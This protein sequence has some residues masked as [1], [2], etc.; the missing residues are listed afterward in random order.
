MKN[1]KRLTLLLVAAAM[2]VSIGGCSKK[3]GKEEQKKFDNFLN[4][5]FKSTMKESY[6]NT[7]IFL[8][9]P[10]KYGINKDK[11]PLQ[12]DTLIS[13][14]KIKEIRTET[15][16]SAEKF[17]EFDRDLLTD[18]QKDN[19][20]IYKYMLDINV[21]SNYEKYDYISPVFKSMSGMHTQLPILFAD[22]TIRNED[23]IKDII[24]V[25]KSTRTYIN[26]LLDYTKKQEEKGTLMVDIDSVV[27]YCEDIIK[28]KE[29]SSVLTGLNGSIDEL[30]L[31]ANKT[32]AYK[33]QVKDAFNSSF[34]P[35]Y[36]DIVKVMKKLDP[37]K[38]NTLGLS[39]LKD[40]KSYYE[41]LFHE[42]SGSDK[43]ILEVQKDLESLLKTSL[44][45]VQETMSN[46]KDALKLL[47][48]YSK[49]KYTDFNQ[50]MKDL[51]NSISKDF[52][53]VGKIDYQIEP[54][55][56][57]LASSGIA[58]YFNLP[59]IDG[60][61]PKQIRVNT[62]KNT[63]DIS[64]LE[65]FM[66][67]AHEGLPGHM[68]QTAYAYKNLSSPWRNAIAHLT[69]Y[70]EG[71]A[72]YVE[73]YSL[74]YLPDVPKDVATIVQNS[75]VFQN[76]IIALVDIGIH[77]EGW[78][79]EQTK[80][81]LNGYGLGAIDV[82]SLYKQIQANPASFLPYY[83]GY[84]EIAELKTQAQNKLKDKFNDL[85]FHSAILKSG[86]APFSIVERNVNDY[87]EATK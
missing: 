73:L 27:N 46:N 28:N 57:E 23:D 76:C 69:S 7:H 25:M 34:I 62:N 22:I 71:Y 1:L 39:N 2:T 13:D 85:D 14:D 29:N 17:Y 72:T 87:I 36:E 52:P 50:I 82:N 41:I 51:N 59:A 86:S 83:V 79:V 77:H 9:N 80:E 33:K 63:L 30:K 81:F 65:T 35:A 64:A 74:K 84:M 47:E 54:I 61:T 16:K 66:T 19:Y 78:T 67:V 55:G 32:N 5:E 49:T 6:F 45:T 4:E 75:T 56:K 20:D 10:E 40:G 12:I 37:K 24:T 60:T 26:S 3:D 31:D 38:N 58:A 44:L 43:T 15:E 53:S 8:E 68:Y 11:I 42:A 70:Q 21:D 48:K 18:E